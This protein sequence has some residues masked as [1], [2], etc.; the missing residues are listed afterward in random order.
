MDPKRELT[1]VDLAALVA[2]LGRYEG[3]KLDK[4]YLYP[5][6]LLRLK[7]RDYDRGRIELLVEVGER[8][9]AGVVAPEHVPDAPERPPNFAMMLRN[10]LSGADFAGVSQ[11]EFDRVL[12]FEFD[13]EDESTTVVAELFGDGNLVVLDADG[14]V[15]DCLHTVRLKSRTVAPGARYEFP[16]QRFDPLTADY[17]SFAARMADSDTD[18]VRT[19]A[20]QLNFGGLYAEELCTRAGVAKTLDIADAGEAEFAA[21]HG[22]VGRLADRLARGTLDPRIYV[23]GDGPVDATPIALEERAALDSESFETF[24]EAL[25]EYFVRLDAADTD[26]GANGGGHDEPAFGERIERQRRIVD[27]QAEAIEAFGEQANAERAKA[28]SLYARYDLVTEVLSTVREAREAGTGWAEIEDRLAEGAERGIPAAEAIVDVE[29]SEGVVL[30]EIDGR[31]VALDPRVGVEQNADRLYQEAKRIGGKQ[32]GAAAALEESRAELEAL[33]RRREERAAG[34]DEA[35]ETGGDDGDEDGEESAEVDWLSR[36]SIPVKR[37]EMWYERFRWFHTS[38][39]FLVIG[40]RDADDNETLVEKYLERGDRFVHTQA[41][42]GP[43]TVL[44]ATGPSEPA[45]EVEFPASSLHEAARFAVSYSSVWKE[46]A[47]AGD[48]YM[49]ESEQVSKTP[50]SGEYLEKGGFAVRGERTYFEDTPV[51]VAVGIT[52]EPETRVIGGPPEPI[53]ERAETTITVEP[54]RYAQNDM[55]KLLYREF[56]ERFRDTSFVRKVASP[57]LIAEFLPPGGS[58]RVE[59]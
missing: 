52:C 34:G 31:E 27:Q 25:E 58:R 13:R 7:L 8:K 54:G 3:A 33:E 17:E 12:S 41:R 18:V 36:A 2:E 35:S 21:L 45:R 32:E 28:E 48:A 46:G 26:D 53:R 44:K 42:G 38:E 5:K 10:R 56:R 23:D 59:K 30:I 14:T 4:A 43:V 9:R 1:S 40:G 19:L 39:D 37:N 16:S 51:G 22:A 49:V 55:A 6:D 15:V 20:T 11:F 24:T 57:D 47:F 29:P 50:E